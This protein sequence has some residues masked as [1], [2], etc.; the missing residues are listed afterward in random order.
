M[1]RHEAAVLHRTNPRPRLDWTDG[2]AVTRN[3]DSVISCVVTV[4]GGRSRPGTSRL[5]RIVPFEMVDAALTETNTVQQR[6]RAL[7]S[8]VVVYPVIAAVLFAEWG[9]QQ[10][11]AR[12]TAAYRVRDRHAGRS[13]STAGGY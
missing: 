3:P 4:A 1:L 6:V 11:W 5:T 13:R 8:Q 10:V 12:M 2:L 7:P 9:Y